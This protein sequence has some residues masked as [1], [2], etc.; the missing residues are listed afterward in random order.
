[1][2]TLHSSD[3]AIDQDIEQLARRIAAA[4]LG[5]Y[6]HA[7]AYVAVNTL[8]AAISAYQSLHWAFFPALGWGAGLL[9]HGAVVWLVMPGGSFRER[10]VEQERERLMAARKRW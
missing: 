6:V 9:I 4:K 5:W 1:M 8:L 7:L 2:N 10:M 3:D